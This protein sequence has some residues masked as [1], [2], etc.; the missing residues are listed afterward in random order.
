MRCR[1]A[2]RLLMKPADRPLDPG[3][4]DEL[5]AHAAACPACRALRS[6]LALVRSSLAAPPASE[7]LPYFYER[8]RARI[9]ERMR[10]EPSP[11]WIRWS[12]RAVPVSLVLIGF[13]VGAI[14][15][16]SPAVDE[17]MS[18]PEALLLQNSNPLS[19]TITLLDDKAENRSLNVIFAVNERSA[20]RRYGP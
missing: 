20:V 15:F 8:L 19:E 4:K 11:L 13:F 16:L 9:D 14:V 2:S 18:Q 17:E 5:D 7:P 6:R 3:R 1:E 10:P 12:V